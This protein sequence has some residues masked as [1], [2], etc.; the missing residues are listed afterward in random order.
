MPDV[1]GVKDTSRQGRYHNHRYAHLARELGLD[2]AQVRDLGWS[3]TTV[4]AATREDYTDVLVDL[5]A[6]LTLWR[7]AETE[8]FPTEA[9][10]GEDPDQP[11]GD[12]DT[13]GAASD[14]RARTRN[15][16]P[17]TCGCP[18]RIRVTA[19]VLAL[20]TAWTGCYP[21]TWNACMPRCRRLAVL[22]GPPTRSTERLVLR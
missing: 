16:I 9:G 6:A 15:P 12:T 2:V 1:R 19:S 17:C 3:D 8:R 18:R 14:G 10:D 21:S 22:P 7:R 5:A 11:G 4:P 13:G 20:G